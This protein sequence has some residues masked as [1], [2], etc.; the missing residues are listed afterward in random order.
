MKLA[1]SVAAAAAL[2]D[3]AVASAPAI[4]IKGSKFFYENNGTEFFIRGV[5]YQPTYDGTGTTT[6]AGTVDYV[7]PL[8][9]ETIC[10]RDLPYLQEL[11][12]NVVRV[13][14][15][16]PDADHTTCMNLLADAGIYVLADLST[17][18]YSITS[19]D[20]QW[21]LEL[22][23]FYASVVDSLAN[24][25]NTMGFFAGN[26]NSNRA[27]NTGASAFVKAAVRDM[28]AYIKT[29]GYRDIGVGYSAA[30]ASDIRDD[31][32]AYFNCGDQDD[33]VDFFG[34]NVYEWCGDSSYTESGYNVMTEDLKN[35]SVP[36]F[37]SEYGCI[38][39]Q[40]RSFSN[41]PVMYGSEMDDWLSGGIVYE[42]FQDAN[43]YGLV[44]ISDGSVSTLTGFSSYSKEINSVSPTGTNSASYT[45]TNTVARSCPTVGASWDAASNLPPAPNAELCSCMEETL[46]CVVKDDVSSKKY[47]DMFGT[48]CG[49]GVCGG[50][51]TNTTSGVYGA[52]SMC[53]SKQMLNWA[54]NAYYEENK[55][56]GGTSACDFGGSATITST[57]SPTGTCSSLLKAVGTAGTGTVSLSAAAGTSTGDSSSGSS[58]S[59]S[60]SAGIPGYS[61]YTTSLGLGQLVVFVAVGL[62]SGTGMILL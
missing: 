43:E 60:S 9:N 27:N 54:L 41:V 23:D 56:S 34:D 59:K 8:A 49:Y 52:Y 12:T 4:V 46:A 35:Y 61:S 25:T 2:V 17:S 62:L 21:N 40:P 18:D 29:K 38:T 48:V 51:D 55:A 14:Q 20:P 11:N 19:D 10:K 6:S 3:V 30:D 39:V 16:D 26:E 1:A 57:V 24:Y 36:Y 53:N 7:D 44:T 13:Y 28:K 47:S 42:Y 15:I 58:G 32:V 50:I 22:Y 5:A 45:P 31:L 33:A 37:F